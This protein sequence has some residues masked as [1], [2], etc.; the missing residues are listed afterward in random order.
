MS[1]IG[2]INTGGG[3]GGG[4]LTL[5]GDIGGPV[6]PTG[7]GNINLN[8]GP[9]ILVTGNPGTNSLDIALNGSGGG[10]FSWVVDSVPGPISLVA[11]IGHFANEPAATINYTLPAVAIVGD[12]FSISAMNNATSWDIIQAAGQSIRF[13]NQLSTAGVTG[14]VSSNTIG[15]TITFVCNVPNTGF[16]VISS[17]GNL[18]VF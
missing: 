7:G 12:T 15:D 16:W 17:I 11:G 2:A 1:Q 10:I 8:G 13:G 4:V 5:S 6:S 9:G 3:G 14:G 18:T